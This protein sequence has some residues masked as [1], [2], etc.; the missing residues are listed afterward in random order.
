MKDKKNNKSLGNLKWFIK[1]DI[2]NQTELR[3]QI[4]MFCAIKA[5]N[6]IFKNCLYF[7][8]IE[9]KNKKRAGLY[10]P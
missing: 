6:L 2:V 10:A 7:H 9:E 4:S 1:Q 8:S 5:L 3:K